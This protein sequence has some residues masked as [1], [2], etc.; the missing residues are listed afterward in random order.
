[1]PSSAR[2]LASGPQSTA[3]PETSLPAR[4]SAS[5]FASASSPQTNASSSGGALGEVRGGE[6][7][8]AGDDGR[9]ELVLRSARRST[10]PRAS[11]FTPPGAEGELAHDREHR[12]RADRL[13]Q[14][15]RGVDGCVCLDREDDEVDAAD[16]VVVV[17]PSARRRAQRPLRG[18][19]RRRAS[20]SRPRSPAST[21][22][23]ATA[24]PKLARAADDRDFHARR[25]ERRLGEPARGVEVGHQR[26]RRRRGEPATRRRPGRTRRRRARRSGPRSRPRR[27]PAP[28]RR[29]SGRAYGLPVP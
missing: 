10:W 4:S 3:R 27:A 25:S 20:R 5:S 11:G 23:L 12:R 19:A 18:P 28:C 26:L 21:S 2:A 9:V 29:P 22:R 1:M 7:V 15:A 13:A 17:R 24:C 14:V 8:Q 6:R 16:G